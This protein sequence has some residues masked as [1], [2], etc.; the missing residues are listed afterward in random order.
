MKTVGIILVLLGVLGLL[1]ETVTLTTSEDVVDLG[2]VEIER[3]EE[4][5]IPIRPVASAIAI[6]GGAGIWFVAVRDSK[7]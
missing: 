3:Q 4:R 2:P 6:V 5:S 7:D 1:V